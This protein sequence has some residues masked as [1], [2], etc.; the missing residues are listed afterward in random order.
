VVA[1]GIFAGGLLLPFCCCACGERRR[2][3]RS[4]LNQQ[5]RHEKWLRDA[6]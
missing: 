5:L 1:V 4:S 6:V 2:S 3:V